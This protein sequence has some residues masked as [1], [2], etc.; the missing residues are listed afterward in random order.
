MCIILKPIESVTNTKILVGVQGT[1]ERVLIA[2]KC[3]IKQREEG[4]LM[5]LA[6]PNPS[7]IQLVDFRPYK[8][9]VDDVN[10]CFHLPG[11]TY[12]LSASMPRSLEVVKVGSYECSIAHSVDDLL[13]IDRTQLGDVP[14]GLVALL[15]RTYGNRDIGFVV[16]RLDPAI[17]GAYEPLAYTYAPRG[18]SILVPTLH[19]HRHPD[20]SEDTDAA[21]WDHD[22]LFLGCEWT[23]AAGGSRYE[24]YP[25]YV[26]ESVRRAFA[27]LGIRD[28]VR[29]KHRLYGHKY[30]N[31]DLIAC[32]V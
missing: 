27:E 21:D 20:G 32:V 28:G 10:A 6:V 26:P 22:I 4:N 9:L 1:G 16:A 29:R 5:V 15:R 30:A 8:T 12:A 19:Y 24:W 18:R 13:R 25:P 2:Y 11:V 7:S 17:T 31:V 23:Q 3:T 14:A